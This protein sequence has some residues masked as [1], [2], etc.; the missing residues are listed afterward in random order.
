MRRTRLLT[1]L[2]TLVLGGCATAGATSTAQAKPAK[3]SRATGLPDFELSD[4]DGAPVRLSDFVGKEV[5]YIDF[6]AT[7]CGPCQAELPQLQSLYE[8]YRAKGFVVLGVAMDDT[9]TS[10]AV[11]SVA[12][13]DGLTFPVLLDAQSRAV[14]LFNP[15]K[16]APYGLLI[17]RTGRIVEQRGGFTPGDERTL[18]AEIQKSL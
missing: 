16:T 8:R 10:G 9:S 15:G 12:R 6:W 17:D 5:V 2:A 13:K 11:A 3:A 18:E 7:W 14:S 1:A 4:T